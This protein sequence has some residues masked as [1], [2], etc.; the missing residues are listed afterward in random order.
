MKLKNKS[1]LK[2][3]SMKSKGKKMATTE[4]IAS[5]EC[6]YQPKSDRYEG[7][8]EV[9]IDRY[10]TQEGRDPIDSFTWGRRSV[11][12]ND[13]NTKKTIYDGRNVEAPIEW[14]D[15]A[16]KVV[17]SKYFFK[18]NEKDYLENSVKSLVTR[19]AEA[20][21][22][23]GF[24][25]GLLS[26]EESSILRDELK[27]LNAGQYHA[28][29]SPVWFNVGLHE[30]YGV[31]EDGEQ[32]SHWAIVNGH[33]TNK[34]DAYQ[35]PQGSACFIQPIEDNMHSI[36]THGYKEGMLFKF[37]SGTGTNFSTLRGYNEPLSGGG[38]AS[39]M[40]S[41]LKIFDVIA[42]RIQSGG[43]TR[44]AAKMVICQDDHPDLFRFIFWKVNEEKKALWLSMNP[45][46]APYDSGDLESDAYKTVDGQ[47]SNNS[48]RVTDEFM[49]AALAGEDWDLWFRTANRF[50]EEIEIPLNQYQ[51]DRYLPDKRFIKRLTNKRK[52]I[53]A[54]EALEMICRAAAVMGDPGMQYDTTINKWHTCPNSGRIN[55]S[56]PCSEYMF[57]DD[58]ACNLASVRL[59][60]FRGREGTNPIIDIIGFKK[61][62]RYS[63]I[64]KEILVDKSSYPSE[65]IAQNSHDYRPLGLG[66]T[67]AGALL[68]ESGIPY[69]S[70]EGR[71]IVAAL[72]SLMSAHAYKTS[73]EIAAR[74]GP[75]NGFEKNREPMLKVMD[76]HRQAS[77]Q[78]KRIPNA[79]GLD[80][81]IDTA[82]K[83][84][85]EAIALGEKYG[86]RNSQVTVIA[87]TGTT[88]IMMDV[89]CTGI[90]PLLGLK[91]TKGL[92]GGGQLE[93]D[94][95]PS[96][97]S[98]LKKLG[99]NGECLEKILGYIDKNGTVIG[100]PE[101]REE[102][103]KVFQTS[104][105]IDN[106]VSVDGHLQMMS[107]AQPFVSGAISKTVNLPKGS[108]VEDVK[109]TY[110]KG[111]K[112]GLK[113]ISLYIDGS[114]GIQ[115]VSLAG[116]HEKGNGL[117]WGER[118]KPR[119]SSMN[120]GYVER[121]GWNITIGENGVHFMV[122]EYDDR[123]PK[124]SPADFFVEF[125]RAGSPF[126]AVYT[127]WAKEASRNRQRGMPLEEFIK[128]NKGSS[129]PITG[130]TDHPF[131]KTCSGIKDFFT[132]LIQLE[133]LG[134][135]SVCDVEP[136]PNQI[137]K[138]R[139]NIL[140][141]RRREE[142][143]KS[144]I[145]F[146]DSVLNHGKLIEI[147]PLYQDG[148]ENGKIPITQDFCKVCGGPTVMS[149]ASCRKCPNC[150]EAGGCG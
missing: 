61:A 31:K 13:Y 126:S 17:G 86:Y 78:I 12:I 29:N 40:M 98:G 128:H 133:Y 10:F 110:V 75:F 139:C 113:S 136:T 92:A 104:F 15:I 100:A 142:H 45:S 19:V 97:G 114:K 30:T 109:E 26:E 130:F 87:P 67:D 37:G 76:M 7:N 50:N 48:V 47:N 150:G 53:N 81:L 129:D 84:W 25:Q 77:Y 108:S 83:E 74:L 115:P 60:K 89:D 32:S 58:T 143:Y 124:D 79:D 94:L 55:A 112:L 28:F 137:V 72:T 14:S 35:R 22:Y 102:H 135:T 138:L 127:D 117:K 88:G 122:G 68:M 103:Y 66:Y 20:I 149:G 96:I 36:L 21:A 116:V 65:E 42:G 24:Q 144:R 5:K 106:T 120:G 64:A 121:P 111:W 38:R 95:A 39:G 2:I 18:G 70:D 34:I 9:L 107:V 27:Y 93:R 101:L 118:V 80:E 63:T 132:K 16:V 141:Q 148:I 140:A 54:S 57:L 43:K 62:V 119:N 73:A 3:N 146:I 71:S 123:P 105:G 59:T 131:I 147:K 1:E 134:D 145:E 82:N 52:T 33:V 6:F 56:N 44:R 23:S 51:D 8:S 46:W 85:D 11:Q 125:G 90:E 4:T 69:D 99:Y 41:F 91:T 49:R